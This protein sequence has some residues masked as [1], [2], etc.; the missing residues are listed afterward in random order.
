MKGETAKQ[1]RGD[2]RNYGLSRVL[3]HLDWWKEFGQSSVENCVEAT[4]PYLYFLL[5]VIVNC[6]FLAC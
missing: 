4:F 6:L 3:G 1:K 2:W 5:F